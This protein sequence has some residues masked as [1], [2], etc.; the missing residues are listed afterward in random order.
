[1]FSQK[2]YKEHCCNRLEQKKESLPWF[3]FGVHFMIRVLVY[4]LIALCIFVFCS[5]WLVLFL[6]INILLEKKVFFQLCLL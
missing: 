5:Q 1:M 4:K 2:V 6:S 3:R